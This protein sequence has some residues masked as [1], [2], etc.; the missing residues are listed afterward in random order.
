MLYRQ[1]FMDLMVSRLC[2][3]AAFAPVAVSLHC[4][5][6]L[7][8]I[9]PLDPLRFVRVAAP[10]T[11]A[12]AAATAAVKSNH[13]NYSAI[14]PV[15]TVPVGTSPHVR[16]LALHVLAVAIR[17]LN[18]AELLSELPSLVRTVLPSLASTLVDIR[19]AVVF[20]LVEAFLVIGD[21]LF[22]FVAE[23]TPAQRKL[24]T[25][26]IEKNAQK[27]AHASPTTVIPHDFY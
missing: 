7:N 18:S 24:L 6:I 5:Q 22:P 13:P 25:I 19:K 9:A 14:V 3:A 15:S 27:T 4:E 23:L 2:Q 17:H 20:V 21:A 8:E 12:A 1:N 11:A 10:Y 16:L 26:Y